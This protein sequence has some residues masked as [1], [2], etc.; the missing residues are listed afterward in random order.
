MDY[1]RQ[2]AQN[3]SQTQTNTIKHQRL[4]VDSERLTPETWHLYSPE[5]ITYKTAMEWI[6][7]DANLGICYPF[8][9]ALVD[10]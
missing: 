10:V 5:C 6:V 2:D 1:R 3:S 9:Q 7:V 8:L 4:S